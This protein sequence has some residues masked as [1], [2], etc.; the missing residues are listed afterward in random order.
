MNDLSLRSHVPLSP[1]LA[2]G[3]LDASRRTLPGFSFDHA[4]ADHD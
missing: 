2:T 1:L 4:D 3:A